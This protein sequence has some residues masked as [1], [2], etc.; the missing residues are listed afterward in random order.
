MTDEFTDTTE[1]EL[2]R[3][4]PR[5]TTLAN[6]VS[7]QLED[8]IV[9][10]RLQ[11]GERLPAERE[12]ARQFGVSRTV[13]REAVRSLMAK[14]MLEVRSGSGTI[15]CAPNAA[16]VSQSMTLFLRAGHPELDYRKVL[17]VRSI[18]EVEIAALAAERRTDND[19]ARM[20]QI[21]E[22]TLN[23]TTRE[24][25]VKA[26]IAFHSALAQATHNE[27]FSLLLDSVV[28]IMRKL[29]EMAFDIP[30]A[31]NRAHKYHR[32]ILEQVKNAN[33]AGARQAMREH[34]VEA[35]DT[36]LRAMA[37]YAT[38]GMNSGPDA[39]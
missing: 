9:E 17:E 38:R 13:I 15:V 1:E 28:E 29:R 26:D 31:P 8:L 14:G 27:I 23:T 6:R 25:Y 34:L 2:F 7:Q 37:L 12:L 33:A 32:A 36:I 20:E 5:E 11:P 18:L 21:L 22:E 35:E 3:A 4:L 19:I 39:S 24:S 16:A 30:P 10:R